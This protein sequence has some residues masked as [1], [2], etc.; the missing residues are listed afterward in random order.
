[1]IW[2]IIILHFYNFIAF[3]D[4]LI[5]IDN[6]CKFNQSVDYLINKKS[7]SIKF[8]NIIKLDQVKLNQIFII[9]RFLYKIKKYFT[10]NFRC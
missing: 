4:R 6:F 1:M 10:L 2:N 8:I 9:I 5:I 7:H 3:T